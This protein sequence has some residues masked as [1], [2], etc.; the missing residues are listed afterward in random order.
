MQDVSAVIKGAGVALE[1][2]A[3]KV[4]G[5]AVEQQVGGLLGGIFGKPSASAPGPNDAE[6]TVKQSDTRVWVS[7]TAASNIASGAGGYDPRGKFLFKVTFRLNQNVVSLA[8]SLGVDTSDLTRDLSYIVKQIDMPKIDFDYEDVN[9]YNFRTKVLRSIKY[10]ELTVAFY[11]DVSNHGLSFLNVYAQIIVPI[12]RRKRDA[13]SPLWDHGFS[14]DQSATALNT[15]MRAQLDGDAISLLDEIIIEQ[16]YVQRQQMD[17]DIAS[18]KKV[19]TFT[20]TNPRFT[21]IDLSDQD[22]EQGGTANTISAVFD[23][24]ALFV[25]A[26]PAVSTA[27]AEIDTSKPQV[28][29]SG[30]QQGKT[31]NPFLDI[32]ANQGQRAVNMAVGNT[33]RKIIGN[34]KAGGALSGAIG[35]ISGALGSAA[36]RTLGGLSGNKALSMATPPYVQDNSTPSSLIPNL[37]NRS[38]PNDLGD[39]YG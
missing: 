11:D 4:F 37:S 32:I 39:F 17:A 21:N 3:Y 35:Q 1:N 18:S 13:G 22:H 28:V 9:M 16:F 10:R 26:D 23:F 2:E 29:R 12:M 36:A 14:F 6:T 30:A 5:A 24:D 38:T 19:N 7:S 27:F 33:L 25:S 34:N 8:K 15:S 31:S 20:F